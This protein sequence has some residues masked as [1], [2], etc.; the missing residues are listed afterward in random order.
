MAF[1]AGPVLA[2]VYMA[3][4]LPW[5]PYVNRVLFTLYLLIYFFELIALYL[6]FSNGRFVWFV[7]LLTST[8]IGFALCFAVGLFKFANFNSFQAVLLILGSWIFLS[9]FMWWW[10]SR[11]LCLPDGEL[12]EALFE[13]KRI[14]LEA[15]TY[16][17]YRV[18][19][20][21]FQTKWSKF[22][23]SS[24]GFVLTIALIITG[25]V[26][27][28]ISS[29]NLDPG[30][31]LAL[32]FAYLLIPVIIYALSIWVHEW[33]WIMKW[34]KKTGRKIYVKEIIEWKRLQAKMKR[35]SSSTN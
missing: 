23:I 17:P 30:H 19:H 2:L 5:H 10:G 12:K 1:L 8:A 34:E 27:H 31:Y 3:P 4:P 9:P 15:A 7:I 13:A 22:L 26:S 16:S 21:L 33:Q 18:P 6:L 29:R 14:D 28:F 25:V 32:F 20:D 35:G 11:K 24:Y